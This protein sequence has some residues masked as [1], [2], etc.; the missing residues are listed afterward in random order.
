MAIPSRQPSRVFVVLFAVVAAA[1]AAS[2]ATEYLP[3]VADNSLPS[4]EYIPP[5]SSEEP[6]TLADDGYRYKI[7]RKLKLRLRRDVNELPSSEYLPPAVEAQQE[8]AVEQPATEEVAAVEAVPEEKTELAEDGYRYKTV[9]RLKYRHRRDVSELPANE[10]LPPTE[11]AVEPVPEVISVAEPATEEKTELAEDGYRYKTVRRLK[12]RK[13]RDVNELPANEYL[14][15]AEEVIAEPVVEEVAAVEAA[16]EEKTELAEDGYRYKTVRRLK[17]RKRRDVNELPA[18]EYLPPAEEVV[19]EPVA[20]EVAAVEAA[21]E[22]NTEL[23]EDGYRY[24]TVRRLKY[25]K[26]RDVNELPASEYLP[27]AEEA[28]VE[29]VVEE[30]AAVE[31]APEENTELAEDGYRY[32]T[33][34]RLKYR[35]RRDVNEL[36]AS[37][38]LPPAEEAVVEPVV[39]EVAAVEAAPQENTELAEDGYRY[40]TVRRLKYRKRRDV[41]ELPS[42]EYLPP[43]E[44]AVEPIPEVVSVEEVAAVEAVPEVK[45]ELA[46]DG[47]RYKTVRRLK[48]RKRRDVNEL[49]S[50]E[51][52][53]PTEVAVEPVPEVVSVEEVAAVEAVP[54]VKTELAE[55]GYRYKTVRRLKYRKRR[56]VN[57]LPSSEYLPPTEVAVEPVPEVVSVE[58]VAAVEAVP[59][60]KTE[61]AEDGYRYK[62]VRRLKYRKR[63]D[64]NELPSSEYLPPTE[65]AVEPVP[66]VVSME[67]VAAVEA[68]PEVKTELAEDGYR[69]KT[70]R[71]LKYRKRRDV[72]ELPSNEYLPPTEVAVEPVPEVVSVEEV[73]AVEAVPE[74]KTELAEDG[75][76]YK[77]VRRLKYRKR[78]D[79]S[80][81][82]ANQYLPPTTEVSS[83]LAVAVQDP[84]ESVVLADD[85]YR[86]KTVRR[87]KHRRH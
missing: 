61:L 51:Y 85:G 1:S 86:Y 5:E 12:Y 65:V 31:A 49:P 81:L 53:P 35:K 42:S 48:Y 9:R 75:Y 22:E 60:V 59:E 13:R 16:P 82:P 32:K 68:V 56:D 67:E 4:Q 69:Y 2:I 23:A 46:E 18:S 24:K 17:Y 37:E 15:P 55:D 66:E 25:R 40:K 45:T 79:V 34:R 27:P 6:A 10:Y 38:Y 29:P 36:P 50:S 8:V 62:T 80:E 84:V 70:V 83:D 47:Y 7:V 28:V 57:E 58:E 20:E 74:E 33:V 72:N 64:V 19:A 14:P 54:E 44:V 71:R 52:L 11:V 26:R 41:N 21:P 78:R 39:E 43:T 76:R 30:V 87:L 73:A 63:R 77:T 3:P